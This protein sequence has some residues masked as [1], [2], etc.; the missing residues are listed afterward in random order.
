MAKRVLVRSKRYKTFPGI[1]IHCKSGRYFAY[2]EHRTDIV[3]N[4][5]NE[6]EVKKNLKEMYKMITQVEKEEEQQKEDADQLSKSF[7]T[8]SFTEKLPIL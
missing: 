8:K 2:Y 4:G 7:K 1:L 6:K 5:D 3:A